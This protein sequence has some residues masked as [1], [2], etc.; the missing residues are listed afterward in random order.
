V[1][2]PTE[3]A[4]FRKIAQPPVRAFLEKD[5]GKTWVDGLMNAVARWT[6][7]NAAKK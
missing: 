3:I 4:A 7:E 6:R 5:A 2:T 1:L